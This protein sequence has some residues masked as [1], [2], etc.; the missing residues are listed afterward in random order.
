MPSMPR[1]PCGFGIAS[2]VIGILLGFV[3]RLNQ[4]SPQTQL[5]RDPEN[6]V[7]CSYAQ[8]VELPPG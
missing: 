4:E 2:V 5:S 7:L 8:L 1:S 3:L 6:R